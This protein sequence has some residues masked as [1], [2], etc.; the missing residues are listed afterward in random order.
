MLRKFT[1]RNVNVIFKFWQKLCANSGYISITSSKSSR[2]I[3]CKSQYVN[4][5]TLNADFPGS[6]YNKGFSPSIS[7]LP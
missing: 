7:S 1:S 5:R 6:L 4:A 3:L 2:N